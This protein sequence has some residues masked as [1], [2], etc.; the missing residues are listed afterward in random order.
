MATAAIY[1]RV[2]SERQKQEQTITSQTN[3]LREYA[4][5]SG[6]EVPGD[7][8]F[9]DNGYSGASLIR[10][11]LERL[12]DLVAQVPVAVVLCFAP[13]RLA[14][15]YAYQVLLMEEF[16]GVGTEVRF[17]KGP[18][19]ETPEEELLLQFQGMIAEYERA[20]IAERTRR[21]KLHRAKNGSV[22][23]L[24]GA[25]YG[26]RYIRKTE[27]SQAR[28][29]INAAP[30]AVVRQLFARYTNEQI[31]I[32][33]LARWLTELEIPTATG[34]ST[35]DRST[36]WG[37]LRN[38]AYSGRAAFGKTMTTGEQPRLT[39]PRRLKDVGVSQRPASRE[40][41]REEWIEIPV[42]AIVTDEVFSQ[43]EQRLKDNQRFSP[44]RTKEPSLLQG[45]LVCAGCGYAYCR[46]STRTSK[47]KIYYYRC[48]GSDN[49]RRPQG[50]V[51]DSRPVRQDYLD[52]V[53]WEHVVGLLAEPTLIRKELHRRLQEI[54][55]TDPALHHKSSLNNELKR[56]VKA[57]DRL[58]DAYQEGLLSIDELRSRMPDLRNQ[59]RQ[60]RTHLD[61]IEAQMT[62][63]KTYLQL[64]ENLESFVTRLAE[65]A[66]TTSASERQRII[67]LVVKE[68]LID[69]ERVVIR[70]TIPS[71]NPGDTP[72]YLLRGRSHSPTCCGPKMACL[73]DSGPMLIL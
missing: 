43:A 30:A 40:R 15:K 10:P 63:E 53:V 60:L 31:S 23:V 44:R 47:R 12:R 42:P 58:V 4:A 66:D 22:S 52:G 26:Y 1:A 9:E 33:S 55:S 39:R 70:H 19:G 6:F 34:K 51:C 13:D 7:W 36:V 71:S 62:N 65:S 54:Q 38:P 57:R 69:S 49:Y 21:G 72:G 5:T 64:A 27:E 59:E 32:A 45:L 67:R 48:I 50:R 20:L 37:I 2:S 18:K 8:V 73:A 16:A 68:V 14:R 41:P 35:W 3:A 46:S 11:S 17:L 28:Y 24:S 25:P 56:A 29:E 61:G